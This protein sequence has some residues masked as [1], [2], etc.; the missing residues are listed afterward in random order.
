MLER[1]TD[2]V[3]IRRGQVKT[4]LGIQAAVPVGPL[5][6]PLPEPEPEPGAGG[7]ASGAGSS[8]AAVPRARTAGATWQR[9][10]RASRGGG[11][12]RGGRGTGVRQSVSQEG[13]VGAGRWNVQG[14][15]A[16]GVGIGQVFRRLPFRRKCC[17]G[18]IWRPRE[19]GSDPE[20]SPEVTAGSGGSAGSAQ[21]DDQVP[22][23]GLRQGAQ[24]IGQRDGRIDHRKHQP[25]SGTVRTGSPAGS[26][27]SGAGTA[28]S[29]GTRGSA[30]STGAAGSAGTRG[31]GPEAPDPARER[32]RAAI[33]GGAGAAGV[34]AGAGSTGAS[35]SM[36]GSRAEAAVSG[37]GTARIRKVAPAVASAVGPAESVARALRMTSYGSGPGVVTEMPVPPGTRMW[38]AASSALAACRGERQPRHSGH[39]GQEN[40]AAGRRGTHRN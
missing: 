25:G 8:S 35:V 18:L 5:E 34:G 20:D 16:A 31:H 28:G 32:A 37:A 14:R 33:R 19:P 13:A 27:G 11:T 40:P 29:T 6:W 10:V 12:R 23:R 22:L 17:G 15:E 9:R 7:K 3:S 36:V 2:R 38:A 21:P 1:S 39:A 24:R 4:R 26:V 30:G